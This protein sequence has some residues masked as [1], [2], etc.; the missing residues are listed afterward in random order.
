M[1][2]LKSMCNGPAAPP[3]TPCTPQASTEAAGKLA[4]DGAIVG[5]GVDSCC[6]LMVSGGVD[7]TL[8]VWDFKTGRV[9]ST[10]SIGSP[11]TQVHLHAG[12]ALC[13]TA[14]DDLVSWGCS[15]RLHAHCEIAEIVSGLPLSPIETAFH[16]RL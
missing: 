2:D 6:R 3:G 8:R 11:L 10:L 7:K 5:L 12:S 4:H 1:V 16:Y 14:S 15:L 13:A 9:A